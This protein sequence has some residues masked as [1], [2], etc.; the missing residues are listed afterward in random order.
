M[1][2]SPNLSWPTQDSVTH[3]LDILSLNFFH[4][5]VSTLRE[6]REDILPLVWSFVQDISK[7]LIKRIE[8][9]SKKDVE[10][11]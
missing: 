6:R 3:K 2:K 9:I 8:L 11:L 5:T 7:R 1:Q 4:I 10:A